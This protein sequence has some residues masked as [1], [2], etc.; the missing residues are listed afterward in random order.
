[1]CG[2]IGLYHRRWSAERWEGVTSA[3][4][5][6]L[7]HRGPDGQGAWFDVEAGVG[8]GHRRLAIL[9]LSELGRQP[10]ASRD[11]RYRLV[12]NGEIYN[13]TTLR[14]ELESLGHSFLTRT[15][16]EVMLAAFLEWGVAGAL[17]RFNGMFAFVLWDALERRMHLARDRLGEKPLYHGRVGSGLVVASELGAFGAHPEFE[18]RI[19]R[20]ALAL[21]LRHH[22]VPAPHCIYRDVAK[23]RPGELVTYA[24]ADGLGEPARS[25]YWSVK[26]V[27]AGGIEAPLDVSDEEAED[28]LQRQL[29][30][31]V[32]MRMVADV[33]LGA[34]LS[35]GIDSSLVVA[36]MQLRA[37]A[38]VKTFTVGFEADGYDEAL[39]ARAVAEHLGTDH[40][41]LY[42]G[43]HDVL[44][45][46][47]EMPRLYDEPFSDSSQIPS[48]LV[49]RMAR[50]HVKV[51]LSG[52]GGDECFAGYKRYR[53]A[54]D[55]WRRTR[56][57]PAAGR[58]A[59][60]AALRAVPV[61]VL[62]RAFGWAEGP[63]A[64][65]GRRGSVGDKLHKLASVLEEPAAMRLYRNLRSNWEDPESLVPGA[66]EPDR[67]W[68]G[69]N[70]ADGSGSFLEQMMLLDMVTYL[71]DDILVKVDRASMGV[72]LEM[73]APLLDHDLVELAW[74]LPARTRMRD[75]RGKWLPRQL[76]ARYLPLRLYDRP[77]MGFGVPLADW[78][79]G[80][81]RDW[82]EE[83]LAPDRLRREGYLKPEPIR[84]LWEEHLAGRRDWHDRLWNVLMFQAWLEAWPGPSRSGLASG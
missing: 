34:F 2:I 30:R 28:M 40:H 13:F 19:D 42:L 39:H 25:L 83:L 71:P 20:D 32:S 56:V 1:M 35:G 81:L 57:L 38:P 17:P 58:R 53:L 66:R 82:S 14:E 77:K 50:A 59:L 9:D 69:G 18:R 33:P 52:D 60:A 37:S 3:M 63:I 49:A 6:R 31:S 44:A 47:P 4:A 8:L 5:G 27:A 29:S 76:L 54:L 70:L 74:R 45:V 61:A 24:L 75:G 79:R 64:A 11:G 72:S 84:R 23:V 65:Y 7:E 43:S 46:V 21:Y 51:G 15:D 67:G 36:S 41:E 22:C 78:L 68:P 26:Q 12:H 73:R 80:P 62:D 55:L 48:F 10:M 16:T